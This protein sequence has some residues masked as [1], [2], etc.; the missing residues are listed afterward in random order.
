MRGT[1]LPLSS[2]AAPPLTV[3]PPP[4][5]PFSLALPVADTNRHR[6]LSVAGLTLAALAGSATGTSGYAEGTGAAAAFYGPRGLAV[7]TSG[8]LYVADS[9][10]NVVR[11]VTRAGTA[12][13]LAGSGA[14]GSDDG[15]AGA[16]TF[17]EPSGLALSGGAQ[18]LLYVADTYNNV[19]RSVALATGQVST[20]AGA[21]TCAYADGSGSAAAFC[22]PK[23]LA[24]DPATGVLYVADSLNYRLRRVAPWGEVSTLAGSGANAQTNGVGSAAAFS[25]PVA[26][27]VDGAGNVVVVDRHR[28]RAVSVPTPTTSPTPSPSPTPSQSS[29]TSPTNTPSPTSSPTPTATRSP[30]A[31]GTQSGTLSPTTS[32]TASPTVTPTQTPVVCPAGDYVKDKNCTPCPPGHIN[33]EYERP[34]TS[35]SVCGNGTVPNSIRT[36]CAA[37][38]GATFAAAGRGV[39]AEGQGNVVCSQCPSGHFCDPGVQGSNVR[40][41]PCPRPQAC[42]GT[43]NSSCASGYEG[44]LCTSCQ[45]DHYLSTSG[46]QPC[47]ASEIQLYKDL[48]VVP[49][50]VVA[51]AIMAAVFYVPVKR[52][53]GFEQLTDCIS[54]FTESPDFMIQS[55][56][57]RR[58]IALISTLSLASYNS[59][60]RFPEPFDTFM[61]GFRV[62]SA[63]LNLNNLGPECLQEWNFFSTFWLT[64]GATLVLP[65]VPLF[66]IDLPWLPC[67]YADQ[68][69]VWDALAFLFPNM[70]QVAVMATATTK[71]R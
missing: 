71:M 55:T 21:W 8:T 4:P 24:C 10:N 23:G 63:N 41:I 26:L 57:F 61:K 28:L 46:C 39:G 32:S 43:L 36:V 69:L 52:I 35:C 56:N 60:A 54:A 44:P 42:A 2:F 62:V 27:A 70:A 3:S 58:Y 5:P 11:A 51:L 38:L 1:S 16:A 14:L 19:I 50:V 12:T 47:G 22:L 17:W 6:L 18:A 30:T 9:A 31:T 64:L 34:I 20:L 68:W 66:V 59:R 53:S 25:A 49:V 45:P 65:L 15:A 7:G 33:P 48:L 29:S 40:P 37:C 67:A 13:T